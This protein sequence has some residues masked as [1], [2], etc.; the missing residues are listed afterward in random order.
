[1]LLFQALRRTP[2]LKRAD[3]LCT[4][5][6]KGLFAVHALPSLASKVCFSSSANGEG[7]KTSVSFD[8]N[9]ESFLTTAKA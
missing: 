5:Y 8:A 6:R 3:Q 2:V 1:M 9:I 4:T 7:G